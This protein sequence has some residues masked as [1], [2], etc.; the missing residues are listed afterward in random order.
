MWVWKPLNL[1]LS[2]NFFYRCGGAKISNVEV[3]AHQMEPLSPIQA[4]EVNHFPSR[5]INRT[6][7]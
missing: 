5:F 6:I 1:L 4:L 2:S 7:P 3:G